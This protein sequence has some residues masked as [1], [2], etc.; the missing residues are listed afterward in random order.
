[1]G[2]PEFYC[3]ENIP[4]LRLADSRGIEKSNYGVEQVV[5]STVNF[6]NNQLKTNDP[7]KFIHCIW[8]C[9][10]DTR[11]EDIEV[12]SL[13]RLAALYDNSTLPII[14]VYTRAIQKEFY[15]SMKKKV[16]NLDLKIDF[17]D[18]IAKEIKVENN[19]PIKPK[20]LSKLKNIS[21]ERAKNAISSSCY[22]ALK[23][24]ISDIV[25]DNLKKK[26]R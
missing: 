19:T 17:I 4:F 24:N 5:N 23:K 16:D 25:K 1:M 9:S 10:T 22:S 8:Y 12:E 20:N 21:I 15:L 26:K 7:D 13:K 3:S 2:E 14:F 6:V 18:I 11:F